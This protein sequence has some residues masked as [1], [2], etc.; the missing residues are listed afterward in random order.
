MISGREDVFVTKKSPKI[1]I[2]SSTMYTL[3]VLWASPPKPEHPQWASPPKNIMSAPGWGDAPTFGPRVG[4]TPKIAVEPKI[5][6][7]F[8][9]AAGDPR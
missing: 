8:H 9:S 7:G 2:P 4:G 3:N 5:E 6:Q 1:L